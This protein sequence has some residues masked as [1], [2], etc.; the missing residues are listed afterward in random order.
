M[1]PQLM[2]DL[3]NERHRDMQRKV[4]E[5]SFFEARKRLHSRA[6][7]ERFLDAFRAASHFAQ[8]MRTLPAE[9]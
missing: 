2:M 5:P 9:I 8:D 7:R 6:Q 4:V 1:H 3:V